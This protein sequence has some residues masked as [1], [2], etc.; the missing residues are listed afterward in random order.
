M[1]GR[2]PVGLSRL[3]VYF[4]TRVLEGMVDTDS[5]VMIR[6][7]VKTLVK[8]DVCSEQTWPYVTGNFKK[9]PSPAC[10][11]EAVDH[12]VI[13]YHRISNLNEMK[14]CLADGSPFVFGFTVYEGFESDHVA[15][16]GVLYMPTPGEH[17]V[18]GH[19]AMGVGYDDA[20]QRLIVRSSW[21]AD[22]GMR[23]CFT[24]P[25]SYV[26]SRDLSDDFWTI[27]RAECI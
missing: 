2:A 23:G 21:D 15:K 6:D 10:Y 27:E 24:M 8:Q 5:G 4:N 25:Y 19:A 18:G 20:Q 26:E 22:W 1:D 14:T 17:V 12:Q 11:N 7:A 13:S 16:T 9:K 3:F